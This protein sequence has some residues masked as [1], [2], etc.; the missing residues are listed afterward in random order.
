MSRISKSSPPQP[1]SEGCLGKGV[2]PTGPAGKT[3]K[4]AFPVCS[5]VIFTL[6]LLYQKVKE[7][8]EVARRQYRQYLK[9]NPDVKSYLDN[10]RVQKASKKRKQSIQNM[11]E[12]NSQNQG[13]LW[14]HMHGPPFTLL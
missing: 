6:C 2:G 5:L 7:E 12:T 10:H 3:G 9:D 1:Q 8:L 14:V 11:Q 4:V 13:T